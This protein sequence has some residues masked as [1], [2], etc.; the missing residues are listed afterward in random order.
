MD[1]RAEYLTFCKMRCKDKRCEECTLRAFMDAYIAL[2]GERP[3]DAGALLDRPAATAAP[4]I[5]GPVEGKIEDLIK[6]TKGGDILEG[7]RL[8]GRKL[9][10]RFKGSALLKAVGIAVSA[11]VRIYANFPIIWEIDLQIGDLAMVTNRERVVALVGDT[12]LELISRDSKVF[13][14][15]FRPMVTDDHFAEKVFKYLSGE[16]NDAPSLVHKAHLEAQ[17]GAAF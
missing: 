17:Q 5:P 15:Y 16:E 12:G 3:D 2:A 4:A 13:W 8:E 1:V 10:V 11:L 14:D 9:V 6:Q 7:V